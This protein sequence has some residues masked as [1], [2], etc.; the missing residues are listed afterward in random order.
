MPHNEKVPILSIL[1]AFL[2]IGGWSFGGGVSGWAFRIIVQTRK[3]MDEKEFLLALGLSQ[4]L[5]GGN[6]T[7]L[8]IYVGNRLRGLAGATVAMTALLAIP[9]FVVLFVQAFY[10]E[11]SDLA[12]ANAAMDGV[13]AAAIGLILSTGWRTARRAV[14]NFSSFIVLVV[15][16][17][18]IAVMQ[19]PFIPVVVCMAPISVALAWP[20]KPRDAQ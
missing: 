14:S 18:A 11:I 4:A 13:V 2:S 20:R 8:A 6:V 10:E 17:V 9:F 3:W 5:P 7:N 16:F 12:W 15:T 1:R 19:L